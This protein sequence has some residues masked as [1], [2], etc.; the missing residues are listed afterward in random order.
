MSDIAITVSA[1][2]EPVSIDVSGPSEAVT[3]TAQD[4][5]ESI[6]ITATEGSSFVP[7]Q[8]WVHLAIQYDEL[9]TTTTV[10]GGVV[11]EYEYS[12]G[13]RYR[14]E[15]DADDNSLDAFYTNFDGST[16]SGLVAAR[17]I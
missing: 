4:T 9:G 8:D 10:S 16:V 2:S 3:I 6:H 15:P 5:T 17:T 7:D 12:F 11:T 1:T 13:T 14:F